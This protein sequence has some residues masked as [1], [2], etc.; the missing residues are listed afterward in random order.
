LPMPMPC[1]ARKVLGPW[2]PHDHQRSRP[3]TPDFPT[4][5]SWVDTLAAAHHP[6]AGWALGI[7]QRFFAKWVSFRLPWKRPAA[8]GNKPRH[9]LS[10]TGMGR[11]G[12][13]LKASVDE[14]CRPAA[15]NCSGHRRVLVLL[16][17]VESG[18]FPTA[19][20][21]RPSVR[22]TAASA[23]GPMQIFGKG[24]LA[25]HRFRQGRLAA[26]SADMGGHHLCPLG[27]VEMD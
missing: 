26:P 14:N 23:L 6:P 3:A 8:L 11:D 20:H 1:A 7:A 24:D 15:A 18:C 27:P 21:H 25:A 5:R 9:A 4:A 17:L 13:P 12:R 2:A 10:G 16:A 19:G 22:Q